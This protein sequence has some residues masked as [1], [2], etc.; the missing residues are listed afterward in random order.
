[1]NKWT[2]Q[3]DKL[4]ESFVNTFGSL[5][6]EQLN[7]KPNPQTWS[8]AQNIDHIIVINETYFPL[9]DELK[10]GKQSL[11]FMAKFNFIVNLLGK[12]ILKSVQ[13]DRKRKM[14]T[15]KIWEP[16]KN[17]LDLDILKKFQTHQEALK[18]QITSSEELIKNGAVI[19]SPA[20]KN[21]VYK[22]ETAFDIIVS[23]EQRHFEQAKELLGLEAN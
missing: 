21:I 3:L 6:N 2:T 15:F 1:M 16:N 19:S 23:H 17:K 14:K 4:T 7:Q 11:P 13:P 20:N 5:N 18:K 12:T 8:I 9:I 10:Q 22:L